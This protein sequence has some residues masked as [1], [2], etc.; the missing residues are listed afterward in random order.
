[1]KH[2]NLAEIDSGKN[3][4]VNRYVKQH[5]VELIV[6]KGTIACPVIGH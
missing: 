2:W 5:F 4:T 1:M 3:N 6:R